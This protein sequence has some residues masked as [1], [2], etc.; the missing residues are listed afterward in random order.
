[1]KI[2]DAYEQFFQILSKEI[3][4]NFGL[5]NII[6]IK[7]DVVSY[8]WKRLIKRIDKLSND[9]FVRGFGKNGSGNNYVE[10][11]Y[12]EIF[13]ININFDPTNNAKPSQLL[14]KLTDYRTNKTIYNYQISH[15]FGNT[16]NVYCF[17]APWN[18]IFIPKI[19][20]PFTGHEATGDYVDE[21]QIMFKKFIFEKFNE[22][23]IEYNEIMKN[24]Y[25]KIEVWV[26]QNIIEKKRESYL[27]DFKQIKIN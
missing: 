19:I 25:P 26:N 9:L 5:E 18:I 16:K 12:K 4:F 15:V 8:E 23:I 13:N 6:T 11:L 21:F 2:K 24:L 22:E 14:Q 20:D 10:K 27:K 7:K 1:M 3:F 17:T